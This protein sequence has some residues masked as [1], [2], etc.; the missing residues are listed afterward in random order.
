MDRIPIDEEWFRGRLAAL[1]LQANDIAKA[2]G[3]HKGVASRLLS[4]E[5]P[6]RSDE[7][8]PIAT[9]LGVPADE[10]LFRAGVAPRRESPRPRVPIRGRV[11]GRVV[12]VLAG[13]RRLDYVTA[14]GRLADSAV[15]LRVMA[16]VPWLYGAF[17]IYDPAEQGLSPTAVGRLA[18]CTRTSEPETRVGKVT[19]APGEEGLWR[20]EYLDGTVDAAVRLARAT[21]VLWIRP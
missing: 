15:A 9:L 5:R 14:P 2:I 21:P 20:I 17:L 12:R 3:R 10:V 16:G 4:G 13:K 8:R 7:V 11:D 19:A 18:V 6:M 1:G